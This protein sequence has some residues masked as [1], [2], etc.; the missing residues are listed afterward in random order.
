MRTVTLRR[1]HQEYRLHYSDNRQTQRF[2]IDTLHGMKYIFRT[3]EGEVFLYQPVSD[4]SFPGSFF[5]NQNGFVTMEDLVQQNEQ[6]AKANAQRID[7]Q[8]RRVAESFGRKAYD[9]EFIDKTGRNKK[10][11]T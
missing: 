8:L 4:Q 3:L 10:G 5:Q 6:R 2:F 11:K 7:N 1:W 9:Y